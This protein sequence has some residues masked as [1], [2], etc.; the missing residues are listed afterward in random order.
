MAHTVQCFVR[1]TGKFIIAQIQRSQ[2]TIHW[3]EIRILYKKLHNFQQEIMIA[4]YKKAKL[5][6][7]MRQEL[8][9]LVKRSRPT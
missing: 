8:I 6:Y 4:Y 9:I 1:K 3:T 2:S 7:G 5:L